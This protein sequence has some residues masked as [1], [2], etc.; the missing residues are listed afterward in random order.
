MR[1]WLR[2]TLL[3]MLLLALP[4]FI[5]RAQPYTDRADDLAPADCTAPCFMGIRPGRTSMSQAYYLLAGHAWVANTA[6][7]FPSLVREAS[8]FGAGIP[9]TIVRWRWDRGLPDWINSTAPG[10]VT[11]ENY[12]VLNI[13]IDTHL[14]LGEVL[15]AFGEPDESRYVPTDS[16]FS[17]SGWY[18]AEGLLI[19][20]EGPCPLWGRYGLPVQV[21]FL[22]QPPRLPDDSVP[23]TRVC[24]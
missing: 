13:A 4:I 3:F 6:E 2:L 21:S 8:L 9:R 19:R 22:P 12:D 5:M 1:L 16:G 15:L 10:T 24:A 14:A 11:L 17:Y 7:Q 20:A 18:A 23:R